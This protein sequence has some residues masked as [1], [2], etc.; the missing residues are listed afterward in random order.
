MTKLWDIT[1]EMLR[2][3]FMPA[4]V[5]LKKKKNSNR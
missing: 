1:K 5:V 4:N 3:K 2:G